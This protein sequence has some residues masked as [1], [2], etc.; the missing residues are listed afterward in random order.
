MLLD[1]KDFQLNDDI[2]NYLLEARIHIKP[3]DSMVVLKSI[4][5]KSGRSKIDTFNS[6]EVIATHSLTASA[7]T[8]FVKVK[9]KESDDIPMIGSG[10]ALVTLDMYTSPDKTSKIGSTGPNFSPKNCTEDFW[11]WSSKSRLYGI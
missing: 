10:K 4:S 1:F 2:V 6:K 3:N 8:V 11:N 7:S 5:G 9:T